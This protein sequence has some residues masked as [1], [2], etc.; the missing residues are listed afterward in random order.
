MNKQRIYSRKKKKKVTK[1]DPSVAL[2]EVKIASINDDALASGEGAIGESF[3][4]LAIA[5]LILV[6]P[7]PVA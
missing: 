6:Y 1:F 5:Q 4:L 7:H 2:L 3:A